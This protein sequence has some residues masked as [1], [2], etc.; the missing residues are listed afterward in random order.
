MASFNNTNPMIGDS[1]MMSCKLVRQNRF[2]TE[3]VN[4][5][6]NNDFN[7]FSSAINRNTGSVG[8]I[9]VS[10][11]QASTPVSDDRITLEGAIVLSRIEETDAVNGFLKLGCVGLFGSDSADNVNVTVRVR[12]SKWAFVC[13]CILLLTSNSRH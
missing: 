10:R 4:Y 3:S 6:V 5:I 9:P 8:G 2:I 1:V 7:V 13:I 12:L 11:M